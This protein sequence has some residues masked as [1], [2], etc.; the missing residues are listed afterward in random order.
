MLCFVAV[1]GREGVGES[2]RGRGDEDGKNTAGG[3]VCVPAR[4][5]SF[6]HNE[7]GSF[8]AV[9]G[10]QAVRAVLEMVDP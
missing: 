7:S 1:S 3:R 8:E 6:R 2:K 5:G 9:F 4:H 10:W